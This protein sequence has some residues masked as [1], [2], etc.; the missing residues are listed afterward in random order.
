M[1][2]LCFN[3]SPGFFLFPSFGPEN[4]L[5]Y[6]CFVL[7]YIFSYFHSSPYPRKLNDNEKLWIYSIHKQEL[8]FPCSQFTW[9]VIKILI[10]QCPLTYIMLAHNTVNISLL[11][12]L[13]FN[14]IW[15]GK[16]TTFTI[17]IFTFSFTHENLKK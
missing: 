10:C 11:T 9:R 5:W 8:H 3:K 7:C 12:V 4:S 17:I 1:I 6:H 14:N 15:C 2:F 13:K 16:Y